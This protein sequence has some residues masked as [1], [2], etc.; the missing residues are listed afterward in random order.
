MWKKQSKIGVK[1]KMNYDYS[2]Y[3]SIVEYYNWEGRI[4][5]YGNKQVA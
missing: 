4:L 2:F 3:K 5:G 1:A